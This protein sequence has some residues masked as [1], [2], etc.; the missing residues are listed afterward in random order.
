MGELRFYIFHRKNPFNHKTLMIHPILITNLK[1]LSGANYT[2][3]L[4]A[5]YMYIAKVRVLGV[6]K[7]KDKPS[8]WCIVVQLSD[9]MLPCQL[10]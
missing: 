6:I 7:I 10:S 9:K 5:S 4:I 1:M 2:F 8:K 3:N